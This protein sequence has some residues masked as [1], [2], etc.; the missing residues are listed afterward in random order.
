M[1]RLEKEQLKK[2][3][4]AEYKQVSSAL[5]VIH[6]NPNSSQEVS[7]QEIIEKVRSMGLSG[8]VCG[9]WIWLTDPKTFTKKDLLKALGFRYSKSKKNWYWRMDKDRSSNENPLPLD[10]IRAKY[11]SETISAEA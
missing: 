3:V 11:G 10:A 8:E 7:L 1:V 2:E 6:Q 4:E 5:Q 9:K